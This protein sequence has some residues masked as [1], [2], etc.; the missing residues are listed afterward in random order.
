MSIIWSYKA[1]A[2][3]KGGLSS[4]IT[5]QTYSVG[6]VRH[7]IKAFQTVWIYFIFLWAYSVNMTGHKMTHMEDTESHRCGQLHHSLALLLYDHDSQGTS[8]QIRQSVTKETGPSCGT[9]VFGVNPP[10]GMISDDC[11][12]CQLLYYLFIWLCSSL[13]KLASSKPGLGSEQGR[14]TPLSGLVNSRECTMG[15]QSQ[16]GTEFNTPLGIKAECSTLVFLRNC[17]ERQEKHFTWWRIFTKLPKMQRGH[18]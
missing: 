14:I 7:L 16:Y 18:D 3:K 6:V 13:A 17:F 9:T 8:L 2:H 4:P 1:P 12:E 10:Y 5:P 15:G 11:G